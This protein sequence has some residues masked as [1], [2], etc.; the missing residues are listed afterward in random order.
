MKDCKTCRA[1]SDGLTDFGVK[2]LLEG[3]PVTFGSS[4]LPHTLTPGG[5]DAPG[6]S[7]ST[8][9]AEMFLPDIIV[10]AIASYWQAKVEP[11]SDEEIVAAFAKAIADGIDDEIVSDIH[12][13]A[14][15]VKGSKK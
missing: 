5:D 10:A 14:E 13:A 8:D 7:V 9:Y 3:R 15:V 1:V 2:R 11:A 4:K 12:V 6:L